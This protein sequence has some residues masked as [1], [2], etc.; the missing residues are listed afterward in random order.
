[1]KQLYMIVV[2]LIMIGLL[3]YGKSAISMFFLGKI[4]KE[5]LAG[6]SLAISIANISGYSVI[7]DLAAGM[8]GISSQGRGRVGR[9]NTA[10]QNGNRF[11]TKRR[12]SGHH[13][14][15]HTSNSAGL[16]IPFRSE[17]SS[18]N[19]GRK[20]A[21]LVGNGVAD[22]GAVRIRELPADDC[23]RSSQRQYEAKFGGL[24]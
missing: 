18:I 17:P 13:G 1:M 11:S 24:H 23:L 19:E 12:G 7:S 22:R 5:A 21:S 15:S 6:G 16:P 8:E 20:R 9:S 3:V 14:N 4:G 10:S 2:P